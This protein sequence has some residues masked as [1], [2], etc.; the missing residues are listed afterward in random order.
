MPILLLLSWFGCTSVVHEYETA[1]ALALS[2][3]GSVPVGWAPDATIQLSPPLME[4]VVTAALL[5]PPRFTDPISMGLVTITPD[6]GIDTLVVGA[7]DACSDCLEF[8]LGLGGKV[9]WTSMLVA[10]ETPV[11]I[12][13]AMAVSLSVEPTGTGTFAIGVAPRDIRNLS[14]E[15]GRAKSG[16]DLTGPIVTWVKAALLGW[17]PSFVIT[18]VG[19]AAAPVR[20]VRVSSQQEVI[21]IDLLTGARV[22]GTIPA[23][24]PSPVDGFQVDLAMASLL[25]IARTEAFRAGPMMHGIVCEPTVLDLQGDAFVIGIRLWKTTGAG[26]WHDYEVHGTWALTDGELV[27]SPSDVQD[28]GHSRGA[29]FAD[30][31]VALAEG[32]IQRAIGKALHTALPTRSGELGEMGAEILV[33]TIQAADGMLRVT[34]TVTVRGLV[35]PTWGHVRR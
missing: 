5:P 2:D 20:G 9:G 17:M 10:G 6:I 27:L 7:A 29:A 23:V 32:I 1:R 33:S 14:V 35:P 19:S 4:Q 34:G 3:P 25:E 16:I 31:L 13:G 28:L 8:E 12:G 15:F 22:P 24:L 11:K 18:E 30:P 21:R 26:W